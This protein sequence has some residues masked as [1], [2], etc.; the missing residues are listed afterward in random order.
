MIEGPLSGKSE[1]DSA[2]AADLTALTATVAGNTSALAAKA[3][4]T[5]V[6]GLATEVS[7]KASGSGLTAAEAAITTHTGQI[8]SLNTSVNNIGN[9]FYTKTLTDALLSGKQATL[10]NNGGPGIGMLN[11]TD[12]RQ[13]TAVAPLSATIVYDFANPTA[14]GTN[15]IELAVDLSGTTTALAGKQDFAYGATMATTAYAIKTGTWTESSTSDR[16]SPELH[17][18]S[19]SHMVSQTIGVGDNTASTETITY[20]IPSAYQGGSVL[21]YIGME[22]GGVCGYLYDQE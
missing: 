20:D 8:V 1:C 17:L 6:D 13:V 15:N 10:A 14:V 7:R 5:V 12:V 11:G 19:V 18:N 2:P 9:S 3:P 21:E 4:T 16:W 22:H